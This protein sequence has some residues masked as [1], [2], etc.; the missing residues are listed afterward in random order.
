MAN[1][2]QVRCLTFCRFFGENYSLLT[3][4]KLSYIKHDDDK[5]ICIF[6]SLI[7]VIPPD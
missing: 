5:N 2:S 6:N 7:D 4:V 3:L 1:W